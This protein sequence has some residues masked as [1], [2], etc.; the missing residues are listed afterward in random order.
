MRRGLLLINLGTPKS[1]HVPAVRSYLRAFLTDKRVIDLPALLRY[2][3][4]YVFIL[5]FRAKRSAHAYQSIWTERGSPLLWHSQNLLTQVQQDLGSKYE[6]VLGMRYG[7]PSIAEQLNQLRHCESITILPLYPQYSSAA[8]GSSI[9]EALKI[10]SSWDLIPSITVIRDF[11]QH[12]AY[13]NAQ[14]AVI[15]EWA[16]EYEH[17][18]FSYHGIPERQITKNDCKSVCID[19][20]PALSEQNQGCYKAQCHQSSRL[21]AKELQLSEQ[22]YSTAFQSRLGKT[23]WIKPYTDEMLN[24]LASQGIKKLVIACPSF[25]ADCLETLEEISI[26]AKQQWLALGGTQ[27]I[28]VPCLNE[29]PL[30]VKAIAD[31]VSE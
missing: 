14:T 12:P 4:V 17:I 23:P 2:I 19:I 30:W 9:E 16:N 1:P 25:V 18:L 10:I 28:V 24:R 31:I 11:F 26:R 8:S 5:P 21:L 20:C 15:K 13:I 27:L 6:V 29:H 3:L 22:Q 7:E